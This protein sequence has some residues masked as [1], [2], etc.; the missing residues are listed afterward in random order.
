MSMRH[1]MTASLFALAL[2]AVNTLWI[3]DGRLN[4][5]NTDGPGFLA[6]LDETVPGWSAAPPR[7]PAL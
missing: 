6:N 2:G 5:T 1:W 4:A 3:E 7:A